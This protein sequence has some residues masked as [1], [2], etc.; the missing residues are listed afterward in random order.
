MLSKHRGECAGS[1]KVL[2]LGALRQDW[3]ESQKAETLD[4][5][6]KKSGENSTCSFMEIVRNG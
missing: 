1:G 4:S 3:K 2:R 5:I 6:Y